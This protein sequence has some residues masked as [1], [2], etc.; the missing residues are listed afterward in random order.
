MLELFGFALPN[1][2]L[3]GFAAIGVIC[4]LVGA[5]SR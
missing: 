3:S 1:A 4:C 2:W 5:T